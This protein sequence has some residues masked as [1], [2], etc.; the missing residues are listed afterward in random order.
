MTNVKRQSD[1]YADTKMIEDKALNYL[2]YF[3]EDSERISQF[4]NDAD[5]EP[6]WDGHLYLYDGVDKSKKSLL[7]RV[8]VQVKGTMVKQFQ[9]KK[10]K[11]KLEKEDLKAYLNE[12]T[13]FIVCQIK[14]N[15][16]D[17]KLFFRELLPDTVKT[18]LKDMGKNKSRKTLFHPMTEV[19]EEFEKQLL[20]FMRN[21]KKMLSFV[22][23]VPMTIDDA[24][25]K[26]IN[27]FSFFSPIEST[28]YLQQ[29]K[30]LSSHDTYLYA[31]VS[32]ELNIDFPISGG[33][34]RCTFMREEACDIKV[35]GKVFYYGYSNKIKDGR[36]CISI[37]D[38]LELNLPMDEKDK[39]KPMVHFKSN[40]KYLKECI[41]E[42]E[43]IITLNDNKKLYIG[44]L[45][46]HLETNAKD[47][48][49]ALRNKLKRWKEL[50]VVLDKL[51]VNKSL[52]LT[53]ITEKQ[54]YLVDILLE[55]VGKGHT[56]KIPK[57]KTTFLLYEIGNINLLLWCLVNK[58]GE[59]IIGDYFDG[60]IDISYLYKGKE[61]ISVSPFSYLQNNN[62]WQKIDN[63]NYAELIPAAQMAVD[64]SV[65]CFEMLNYD[66]LSMISAA[67]ALEKCE[68]EKYLKILEECEKLNEW[69][70]NHDSNGE[71]LQI[72]ICNKMQII[73][74]KRPFTE[75]EIAEMNAFVDDDITSDIVRIGYCLLLGDNIRFDSFYD[76][77]SDDERNLLRKSPIWK[78]VKN[79]DFIS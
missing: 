41:S 27:E 28:D 50:Q 25:A 63:V 79:I 36:M 38:V 40:G 30:Y 21:S 69:L 7:G 3:I 76:R 78:F 49:D 68:P 14:E 2:K 11:F 20:V 31:K 10:W 48:I 32:K 22:N 19:L 70:Q 60:S 9:V 61:R 52:D 45:G 55:T 74:R 72:H 54:E 56:V 59:S 17:R 43:F 67:D 33:P 65:H 35:G 47:V 29:L 64:R 15:S 6:C 44:D 62:L 39:V 71:K 42:A 37:G 66:V 16:K 24:V 13:F 5:K 26:G 4:L 1:Y 53:L 77:L 46:L 8:P 34:M 57:Q 12:P 75:I 73:R 58:C 23:C 51:H 18:L